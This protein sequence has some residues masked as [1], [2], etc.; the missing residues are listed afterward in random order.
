MSGG[1]GG[2]GEISVA[3]PEIFQ[4]PIFGGKPQL[5]TKAKAA[6]FRAATFFN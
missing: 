4:M 3:P 5:N 2:G 6:G 1:G